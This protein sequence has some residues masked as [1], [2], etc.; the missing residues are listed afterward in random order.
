MFTLIPTTTSP[1]QT[2]SFCLIHSRVIILIL[3]RKVVVQCIKMEELSLNKLPFS[4]WI[5]LPSPRTTALGSL[6]LHKKEVANIMQSV[7]L[8]SFNVEK[9]TIQRG[10]LISCPFLWLKYNC[11]AALEKKKRKQRIFLVLLSKMMPI[12]LPPQVSV[13]CIEYCRKKL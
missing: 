12:F 2:L 4:L 3:K 1:H 8:S 11:N 6:L 5:F 13:E 9:K 10:K 7:A